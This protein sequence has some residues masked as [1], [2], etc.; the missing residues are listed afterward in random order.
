L[1]GFTLIELLVVIAIIAVL[2][3]LLLPAVQKVREAAQQAAQYEKLGP[4]ATLVLATTDDPENGL[5][6]N[7]TR[8]ETLLH[9]GCNPPSPECLPGPQALDS[10]L[11]ALR[12]NETGLRA[13]LGLLPPLSQSDLSNRNY[14]F[15]YWQ[16]R[17]SLTRTISGLHVVNRGLAWV[18]SVLPGPEIQRLRETS[19]T[20]SQF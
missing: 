2:I 4:S 8:A 5:S 18:E 19:E 1:R 10:V 15:A 13:A 6:N 17:Q 7:L 14:L 11:S 9:V 12:Q 16:L 3:G 20:G